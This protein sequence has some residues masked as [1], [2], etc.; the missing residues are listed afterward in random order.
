MANPLSPAQLLNQIAQIQHMEPGKLTAY[1]L[2]GR[3]GKAGPYYKLQ[4]HENGKNLTQY[5]RP[6]DVAAVQAAVDGYNQF[7]KL[8][9][10]YSQIIIQQTREQRRGGIKKK[11]LNSSSPK[12]RKSSS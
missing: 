3:P 10:E 4:H 11:R 6:E 7:E 12:T 9:S 8:V 5:I 1:Y 2:K